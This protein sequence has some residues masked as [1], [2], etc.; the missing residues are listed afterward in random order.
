MQGAAKRAPREFLRAARTVNPSDI[1]IAVRI[2]SFAPLLVTL[3]VTSSTVVIAA[4]NIK[5]YAVNGKVRQDG[6]FAK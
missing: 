1:V 4:D 3:A 5:A 6:A 2:I